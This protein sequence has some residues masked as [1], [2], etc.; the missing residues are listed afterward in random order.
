MKRISYALS[1]FIIFVSFIINGEG[2]H[3]Y[4]SEVEIQFPCTSFEISEDISRE[5]VLNDIIKVTE[6]YHVKVFVTRQL[7]NENEVTTKTFYADSETQKLLT[8]KYNI[9]QGR[10]NGII[11]GVMNVEFFERYKDYYYVYFDYKD[12]LGYSEVEKSLQVREKFYRE[13]F[14][15]FNAVLISSCDGYI[16]ANKKALG[17]LQENIDELK[18][19]TFEKDIYLIV[20]RGTDDGIID[21]M[22]QKIW[23]IWLMRK[24]S[25]MM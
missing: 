8:E 3:L 14:D 16:Y 10:Y 18:N 19:S 4:L 25:H 22:H 17:Y 15:E 1:I 9:K 12:E 6:E 2:Y 13:Y 24:G 11:D 23:D 20:P 21:E 7:K 5:V